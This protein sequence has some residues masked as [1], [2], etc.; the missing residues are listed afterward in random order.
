VLGVARAAGRW[1]RGADTEWPEYYAREVLCEIGLPSIRIGQGYLR[2]ALKNLLQDHVSRQRL[3][4]QQK[5]VRLTR[6][7]HRLDK[8]SEWLFILAVFSVATYLTLIA[9][10]ALGLVPE[11]LVNKSSK[12]FTFLGVVLPA[13]GGAFAGIR[14][15]GDFERFASIS[16]ITAEKLDAVEQRIAILLNAPDGS[17]RYAQVAELV[18]AMDDIVVSEIENWQ[19][20][21]GGKQIAVPV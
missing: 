9:L 6:V 14:Y 16:E 5:A 19:S 2:D 4:H 3:Y 13:L 10:S 8:L 12:S 7:H 1:P 17:L 18:H 11:A 21:F 15:F 20:V